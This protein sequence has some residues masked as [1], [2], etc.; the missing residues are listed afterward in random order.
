M[1]TISDLELRVQSR[2]EEATDDTGVFWDMQ[3]EIRTAIVEAMNLA[4]I[5]TGDPQVRASTTYDVAASTVFTPLAMPSDALALLRVEGPGGL[6]MHKAWIW[7][8]D[9]HLPGWEVATGDTPQ[10]WFPFGL[11][12]F[13]I[14][15]CLTAPA[16]VVLSYVQMPVTTPPPYS[17]SETVPFQAEYFTGLEDYAEVVARFKEANPEFQQSFP[18][19][20]RS[21]AYL[22]RMSSFAYR[23]GSLRFTR[24][25]GSSSALNDVRSK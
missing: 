18:V 8:L 24:A 11:S 25:G 9:R 1:A 10:F 7:D 6:P 17:G 13:G 16:K 22:E 5:V 15:P 2:L 20:N 19:L 21:L 23:K 3:N 12:Q 14:Y 4:T